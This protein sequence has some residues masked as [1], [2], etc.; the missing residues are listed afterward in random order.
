MS[1]MRVERGDG[2]ELHLGDCLNGLSLLNDKSVT[3]TITDPPYEAEAH[4]DGRRQ[5]GKDRAGTHKGSGGRYR[6]VLETPLAFA[7]IANVDRAAVAAQIARVTEHRAL[8]FCQAEAVAEWRDAFNAGGIKYRRAMPW[9]KPDA[10]PSLHGRWPGQSYESI[11]LAMHPTA[12]PCP[13]GGASRRY[14]FTRDAALYRRHEE[15]KAGEAA[16]HPTMKPLNLMLQL[17]RDFT[18][19]GDLVLDPFTGSGT[20]GVACLSL[21]R[22]FIGWEIDEAFFEVACRRLRGERAAP[23]PEQPSLFG[24]AA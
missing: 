3:V 11:V 9:V 2:W 21:G 5:L 20:T 1:A 18:E 8:A 23:R 22:R 14:E 13:V 16:P 19:P 15:R 24:G 17:V 7:P 4:T 10:M 12:P 6:K